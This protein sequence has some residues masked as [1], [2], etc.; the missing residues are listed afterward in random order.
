MRR[1]W[2]AR[3]AADA[4]HYIYTRD[5]SADIA[6]FDA[7]GR[8]N[9]NQLVRPYLPVL[10]EGRDAHACRALEIGCG[11]GRMT[12]W[13]AEAFGE[14]HALDVSPAMLEAARARLAAAPNVHLHLGSGYDLAGLPDGWFDL[15]FSYIVFQHIPLRAAIETYVREA[16]RVLKSGGTFKFQLNGDQSPE[17]RAHTRDTWLGETFSD[18][19]ARAMLKAA[20]FSVLMAEGAGTQYFVLTAR[21]GTPAMPAGLRPY[22]LPGEP[23]AAAQLHDGWYDAVDASWRPVAPR[24]T[25]LLAWPGDPAR[26]FLGL[27]CWPGDP[28]ASREI[29]VSL[30][31]R[32]IGSAVL[33]GP[34]DHYTEMAAPPS[35]EP[36]LEVRI[37]ITPPPERRYA[38]AL[39]CLGL[40]RP[41][42]V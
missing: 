29:E 17:Y 23:W 41:A 33:E 3:A 15:V 35:T 34:G 6:D 21:K 13:F 26:F 27:Y 10:L 1:D 11:L 14:V 31:G 36:A 5:D 12:R 40:Y 38:P 24:S 30:N 16:A 39:R 19:E 25:A 7:S 9:Y 37:T 18:D 2:D 42:G 20:G 8:A 28:A 32:T 4:R 22:L